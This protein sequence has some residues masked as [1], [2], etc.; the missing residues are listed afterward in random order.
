[1][2]IFPRT[3]TTL[4][5]GKPETPGSFQATWERVNRVAAASIPGAAGGA[6]LASAF[7]NMTG[8]VIG[9]VAG[10]AVNAIIFQR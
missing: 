9:A 5:T 1:M 2:G 8:V 4:N 3:E 6:L 7:G 10:F